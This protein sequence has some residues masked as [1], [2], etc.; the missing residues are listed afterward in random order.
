MFI[1]LS[2]FLVWVCS[3]VLG[4]SPTQ[5]VDLSRMEPRGPRPVSNAPVVLGLVA[6]VGLMSAVPVLLQRRHMRLQQ[7]V[8]T[9]ASEQPLNHTMVRRGVYLNTSSKVAQ[10]RRHGPSAPAPLSLRA[11]QD[12][13]PDPDFDFST[14]TYKGRKLAIVDASHGDVKGH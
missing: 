10:L 12:V 5:S 6:F 13:G 9:Y 2:C 4:S 11:V 3:I 1:E 8:P 7:G 14:G